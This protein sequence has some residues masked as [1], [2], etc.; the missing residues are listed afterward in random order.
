MPGHPTLNNVISHRVRERI[1]R[2]REAELIILDWCSARVNSRRPLDQR[3]PRVGIS[4]PFG[5]SE[6]LLFVFEDTSHLC[7]FGSKIR[8]AEEASRDPVRYLNSSR[9]LLKFVVRKCQN[10]HVHGP[11]KELTNACRSSSRWHAR[12]GTSLDS[13]N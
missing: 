13:C 5:N 8:E 2:E 3:V 11:V 7:M 10:L 6:V 1:N 9:E 4:H 12:V